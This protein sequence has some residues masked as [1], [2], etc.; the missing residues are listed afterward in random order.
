MEQVVKTPELVG[1]IGGLALQCG[2]S[3]RQLANLALVNKN[4]SS[5]MKIPLEK[6]CPVDIKRILDTVPEAPICMN[7]QQWEDFLV[8]TNGLYN[9]TC[10]ALD[11]TIPILESFS[12]YRRNMQAKPL[13]PGLLTLHIVDASE[14]RGY[15]IADILG[16]F[17]QVSP[18]L[19]ALELEFQFYDLG[20]ADQLM[21]LFQRFKHVLRSLKLDMVVGE[22]GD[23]FEVVNPDTPLAASKIVGAVKEWEELKLVP[24]QL[25]HTL[26]AYIA[27]L[28][29]LKVLEIPF[30]W[31]VQDDL[32]MTATQYAFLQSE[33]D[34]DMITPGFSA[35]SS[36]RLSAPVSLLLPWIKKLCRPPLRDII[37]AI[38]HDTM[39]IGMPF[40]D[41]VEALLLHVREPENVDRLELTT[42]LHDSEDPHDED[43]PLQQE[44]IEQLVPFSNLRVLV[45]AHDA[46]IALTDEMIQFIGNTFPCLLTLHLHNGPRNDPEEFTTRARPT[47]HALFIL[48]KACTGLSDLL[49]SVEAS[50]FPSGHEFPIFSIL[51]LKITYLSLP[52]ETSEEEV[53]A[54]LEERFVK[55]HVESDWAPQV[56]EDTS[57]AETDSSGTLSESD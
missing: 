26:L 43:W 23:Q 32:S 31:D 39:D 44:D 57:D 16:F 10:S 51:K 1:I 49:L 36:L 46:G 12:R 50:E 21:E 37:L 48:A 53:D 4:F 54:W 29:N 27:T 15:R 8:K 28:Q 19:N 17:L 52:A 11:L 55:A 41:I 25:S 2:Y 7:E 5:A 24:D 20:I 42:S 35:L 9:I 30:C 45:L 18:C 47:L 3:P 13:F 56:G 34:W 40:H 22:P 6:S 33:V 14:N 38:F